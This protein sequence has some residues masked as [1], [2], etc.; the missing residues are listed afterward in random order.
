MIELFVAASRRLHQQDAGGGGSQPFRAEGA[1]KNDFVLNWSEAGCKLALPLTAESNALFSGR[2]SAPETDQ[3][4]QKRPEKSVRMRGALELS[5]PE[6]CPTNFD[7]LT[8]MLKRA[9]F[10][11]DLDSG[12]VLVETIVADSRMND[13]ELTLK[14]LRIKLETSAPL[15]LHNG[16]FG[17]AFQMEIING[18][19]SAKNRTSV[20]SMD[21]TGSTFGAASG[22]IE[23]KDDNSILISVPDLTFS[24]GVSPGSNDSFPLR[25]ELRFNANLFAEVEFPVNKT[26]NPVSEV[27]QEPIRASPE[28]QDQR[29][30]EDQ[31]QT[32][33]ETLNST[34]EALFIARTAPLLVEDINR[35][36]DVETSPEVSVLSQN[37]SIEDN[38]ELETFV[39]EVD[40][41]QRDLSL[42]AAFLT[43]PTIL[44]FVIL[45]I[46][47]VHMCQ[48]WSKY[49]TYFTQ[50][51]NQN[52]DSEERDSEEEPSVIPVETD[53]MFESIEGALTKE[54]VRKLVY[55]DIFCAIRLNPLKTKIKQWKKSKGLISTPS[56]DEKKTGWDSVQKLAL[57]EHEGQEYKTL[58]HVANGSLPSGELTAV[59]GPPDSGK[60]LFVRLLSGDVSQVS[61]KDILKGS[62]S[63]DG[64]AKSMRRH[65]GMKGGLVMDHGTQGELL[66]VSEVLGIWVAMKG[67]WGRHISNRKI[68]SN[69]NNAAQLMGLWE[70]NHVRV[71]SLSPLERRK[72]LI[73]CEVARLPIAIFLDDP[74]QGLD[75]HDTLELMSRL[76]GIA[77]EDKIVALTMNQASP[78]QFDLIDHLLIMSHG[79]LLYDGP[80]SQING[81]LYRVGYPCTPRTPLPKHLLTAISDPLILHRLICLVR[82]AYET[83]DAEALMS[84]LS[85]R[86]FDNTCVLESTPFSVEDS[87]STIERPDL[88]TG[89]RSE[90]RQEDQG[91][92]S[93]LKRTSK[94]S[95]LKSM[96]SLKKFWR[97]VSDG[98][99]RWGSKQAPMPQKEEGKPPSEDKTTPWKQVVL[100]QP[101]ADEDPPFAEETWSFSGKAPIQEPTRASRDQCMSSVVT[102]IG[103]QKPVNTEVKFL[104][105]MPSA[106]R[107]SVEEDSF[108]ETSETDTARTVSIDGPPGPEP[109]HSRR[110]TVSIHQTV[111][112]PKSISWNDHPAVEGVKDDRLAVITA[113]PTGSEIPSLDKVFDIPVHQLTS[114]QQ[115]TILDFPV[116]V[117]QDPVPLHSPLRSDKSLC[118]PVPTRQEEGLNSDAGSGSN[119]P[120]DKEVAVAVIEGKQDASIGVRKLFFAVSDRMYGGVKTA[121]HSLGFVRSTRSLHPPPRSVANQLAAEPPHSIAEEAQEGTKEEPEEH[122]KKPIVSEDLSYDNSLKKHVPAPDWSS[123]IAV[124]LLHNVTGMFR[125][126]TGLLLHYSIA[127]VCGLLMSLLYLDLEEDIDGMQSRTSA[128][129]FTLS[130]LTVASMLPIQQMRSQRSIVLEDVK[131]DGYRP[132]TFVL[133]Q[134]LP[135]LLFLKFCPICLFSLTFLFISNFSLGFD[136]VCIFIFG[137][138]TFW[139]ALSYTFLA[140]VLL[141][142]SRGNHPYFIIL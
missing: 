91:V 15:R 14:S 40:I 52:E 63:L 50:D 107:N 64:K 117:E 83:R 45:A 26:T 129:F 59:L 112:L 97:S 124:L 113:S 99:R 128:I 69:L 72:L 75:A 7:E 12:N 111:P 60:G 29:I 46:M 103:P 5:F 6:D 13:L 108:F 125:K 55:E 77:E 4:D 30:P 138:T 9:K 140:V 51:I 76:R 54:P 115:E 39:L 62:V 79:H 24:F 135:D 121:L 110:R 120:E 118:R 58:L 109:S 71:S 48:Q 102:Y 96:N 49:Y 87:L 32:P 28:Q 42:A 131:S 93:G 85:T 127:I 35:S 44:L 23:Q 123:E 38:E 137:L 86:D 11:G 22:R 114:F 136:R 89:G 1:S 65:E 130:I 94:D 57:F 8:T 47:I 74:L 2:V 142:S 141:I 95:E 70:K 92:Q 78:D 116:A 84:I 100:K 73:A 36:N 101:T 68:R 18:T 119:Q 21:L 133:A 66:T 19:A 17:A 126:K 53:D 61:K 20:E 82:N 80:T 67:P 25:L 34:R 132:S 106:K 122:Q 88:Q 31:V 134:V 90:S 105:S 37:Q 41:K 139:T 3:L 27:E 81:F 16:Q 10:S 98:G 33:P 104:D 56:P 43:T